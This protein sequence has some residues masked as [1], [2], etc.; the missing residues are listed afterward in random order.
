MFYYI[1]QI[2]LDYIT[3]YILYISMIDKSED[4][5]KMMMIGVYLL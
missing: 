2:N 5:E 3:Y 4:Y 1:N